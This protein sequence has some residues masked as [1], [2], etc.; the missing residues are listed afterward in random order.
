MDRRC[1][2]TTHYVERHRLMRVAAET[3]DFQ[4]EVSSIERVPESRRGL[5][6]TLVTKHS[7]VPGLTGELI[8]LF[9]RFLRALLCRPDA[10]TVNGFARFGAH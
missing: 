3:F 1:L 6:R 7:L 5:S 4:I 8:G 10:G 2:R 9:S